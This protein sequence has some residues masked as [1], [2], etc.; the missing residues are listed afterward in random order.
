MP[1]WR[2]WSGSVVAQPA[3]IAKPKTEA[4]LAAAVRRAPRLRVA[5]SGHSFTPLCETGGTLVSLAE[6][7][8]TLQVAPDRRTAWA[9]AGWSLDRL[10]RAL[11]DEGLCLPNQGDINNQAL[12]GALATGTH[13]TGGELKSLSNIARRFRLMLADGSVVTCGEGE[14]DELFQAQRL[15]LGLFGV[16]LAVEIEVTPAYFLEER[17]ERRPME[18]VLEGFVGWAGERRHAEFWIFPHSDTAIVKFLHPAED[19]GGFKEPGQV[20]E[21]VFRLC[22][23]LSAAAPKF[24]A[25]LQ[26]LLVR[27]SGRTRRVGPAHRIFPSDRTVP[28]EEMEYELPREAGL[29]ALSEAIGWIRKNDLPVTFPF[30][31]RWTAADDIWMSP[32]NRGDCASVS[33]HQFARM[34]W[35]DLFREGEAIFRAAGGRPHWGKRHNLTRDEVDLLYPAAE[36]FRQVRRD[37]DPEGKFLN[38]HLSELFS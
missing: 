37:H 4:E 17:I 3:E 21:T 19:E 11:W 2:N 20:D 32:F 10:T 7:E 22:C 28:F 33:M 27:G 13:G 18:E 34:P 24:T 38:P 36:R 15:S 6:L 29:A 30:E 23:E 1:E 9:P 14:R 12:A 35:Q 5:G 31:F 16:A 26:K 25:T 8:G